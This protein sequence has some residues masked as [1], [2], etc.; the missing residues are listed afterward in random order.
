MWRVLLAVCIAMAS[1]V[2][3]QQA[4]R[5]YRIGVLEREAADSVN[6]AAFRE[7]MRELGYVEG[8][9]LAFEYRS[10]Q[11]SNDLYPKLAA[12][13]AALKVDL[14]VARGTPAILAAKQATRTI[15]IV[16]SGAGDPVRSGLVASLARPGGNVTGLMGFLELSPKRLQLLTQL[17]PKIEEIGVLLNLSNPNAHGERRELE[18]AAQTFGIQ[19]RAYDVRAADD[20]NRAFEDAAR[21]RLKAMYVSLDTLTEVHRKRIA[22]LALKH[23]VPTMGPTSEFVLD[24][25]LAS[26]GPNY[27]ALYRGA[28]NVADRILKGAKPADIPVQQPTQ[29]EL[30]LNAKTAKALKVSIPQRLLV[31]ADKVFE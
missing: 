8:R 30:V 16:M 6:F 27:P 25:G 11:G 15:P 17:F 28:A 26:Y 13:L 14:I 18:A 5:V 3:A 23:R 7:R 19:L 20:L 1:Q 10:S 21:R 9:N 31:S 22:E 29:F 24:G 2:D 12:E 4:G